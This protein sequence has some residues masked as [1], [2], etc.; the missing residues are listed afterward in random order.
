MNRKHTLALVLTYPLAAVALAPASAR[1]EARSGDDQERVAI[2]SFRGPQAQRLQG[3]IESGL[4]NKYYVVPDFSIED[5]AKRRGVA[6]RDP[7]GM[8]EVGRALQVR[9]FLS[10]NVQKRG[11][12]KVLMV[13]RKGDTGEALGRFVVA[14]RRL[15]QLES[16]LTKRTSRQIGAL[17]ARAGTSDSRLRTVALTSAVEPPTIDAQAKLQEKKELDAQEPAAAPDAPAEVA[18][19]PGPRSAPKKALPVAAIGLETRVFNR[20][21]KHTQNQSRLND[22][23]LSGAMSA[24]M[25]ADLHPF[26]AAA[27]ALAPLGLHGALEYGLG[28]GSRVAGTEERLSTDVHAWSVGLSYAVMSGAFTFA[29]GV[30]YGSSNFDSGSKGGAPNASYRAVEPGASLTWAATNQLSLRAA[31][32]Y[33]RVLSAGPLTTADRFPRA[34]VNGAEASLAVSYAVLDSLELAAS[35]GMR[36]YGIA[37]NVIPGDKT[38]AGGAVDQTTWLGLG[39]SYRPQIGR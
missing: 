13:V 6:M 11:T 2:E 24:A 14:N 16:T 38:I 20:S 10:A 12:W 29:P 21:F 19:E 25:S 7:D 34:T 39:L 31:G 32:E 15:D 1:A 8:A 28:V 3:A 22:Y 23:A 5:M 18:D 27:S 36:R 26:A 17:I 33:L 37:T 9:A 30:G 4:M 35:G